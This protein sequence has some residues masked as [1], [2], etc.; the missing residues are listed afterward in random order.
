M[1]RRLSDPAIWSEDEA[2]LRMGLFGGFTSTAYQPSEL[3]V[4]NLFQK[5]SNS[6]SHKVF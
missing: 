1:V 6:V 3:G 4:V 5:E 2:F